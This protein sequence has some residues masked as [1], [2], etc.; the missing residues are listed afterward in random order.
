VKVYAFEPVPENYDRLCRNLAANA[1]SGVTPFNVGVTS[2]GRTLRLSGSPTV[3]TGHY[4]AYAEEGADAM[5]VETWDLMRIL[6][7]LR[8]AR[9]ALLKMDCEGAE[10][11]ILYGMGD[12]LRLV[13]ALVMEVHENERLIA[14]HG[15][16]SRLIEYVRTI[17][18]YV[19]ASIIRIP[20]AEEVAIDA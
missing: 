13:D 14:E 9:V 20:D 10:Y 7:R 4:S 2:D 1:C 12:A 19:R 15:S 3:N 18:P 8:I 6:D 16:A 11:E 5:E 17:V